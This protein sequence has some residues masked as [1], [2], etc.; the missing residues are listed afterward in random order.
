MENSATKKIGI[1]L[2]SHQPVQFSP[3]E[4]RVSNKIFTHCLEDEGLISFGQGS[5]GVNLRKKC[6]LFFRPEKGLEKGSGIGDFFHVSTIKQIESALESLPLEDL[7][8]VR[9]WLDDFIE[10]QLEVSDEF[11]AKIQRAKQPS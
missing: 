5:I 4:S 3:S 10:E 9:D 6:R 1:A 11:K 8:A 2:E 7:Q